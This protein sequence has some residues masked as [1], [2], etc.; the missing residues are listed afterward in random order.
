MCKCYTAR[1]L[2]M[3]HGGCARDTF[4]CAGVLDSRSA[5]LRA[6]A[7][8]LRFAAKCAGFNNQEASPWQVLSWT[9]HV[10]IQT[11]AQSL[12]FKLKCLKDTSRHA[13]KATHPCAIAY[14]QARIR[15]LVRLGVGFYCGAVADESAIGFR[16]PDQSRR[17]ALQCI[18]IKING[19][20][21]SWRLCAGYLRVCRVP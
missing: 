15:R 20:D 21:A 11:A 2:G 10:F 7:I 13:F 3:L 19:N 16:S 12:P 18:A 1:A 4:G 17:T 6:A 14:S 8:S 5:N 9:D